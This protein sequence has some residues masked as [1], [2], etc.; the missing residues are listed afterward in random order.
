[1]SLILTVG[2]IRA[3]VGFI[4]KPRSERRESK[5]WCDLDTWALLLYRAAKCKSL[6]SMKSVIPGRLV[7][8]NRRKLIK[9]ITLTLEVP[10]AVR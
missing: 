5:L 10:K 7:A 6:M 2:F 8:K 9:V 1:M 3:T 4:K